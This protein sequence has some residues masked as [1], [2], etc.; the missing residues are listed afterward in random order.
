MELPGTFALLE[1]AREF[2]AEFFYAYNHHHRLAG[3]GL[4]TSEDVHR[5]QSTTAHASHAHVLT[6]AH[7]L[8]SN[9]LRRPP[10]PLKL[11]GSAWINKPTESEATA[12]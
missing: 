3:L 7:A 1:Q 8:H 12:Q 2:C 9:R 6:A 5:G 10:Q 11:P 4:L